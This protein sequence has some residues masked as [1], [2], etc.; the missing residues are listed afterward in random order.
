M[1]ARKDARLTCEGVKEVIQSQEL[2][3][4]LA[5]LLLALF[6]L[7]LISPLFAQGAGSDAGVP[8]CCRRDGK[9]QCMGNMA[10]PI[11]QG[12]GLRVGAPMPACPFCPRAVMQVHLSVA[13]PGTACAIFAGLVSHPCGV[14][15]VRSRWRIARER[16]RGKRGP[17]RAAFA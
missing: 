10:G 16:S 15:Q 13:A 3:K 6:A 14:A 7:P 8:L 5:I 9:H 12:A 2:R 1:I 11:A 4:L 17:P